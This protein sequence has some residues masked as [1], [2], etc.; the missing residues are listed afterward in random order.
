LAVESDAILD[1]EIAAA[2]IRVAE[3]QRSS[4]SWLALCTRGCSARVNDAGRFAARSA[5]EL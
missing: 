4:T 2:A 3:R 1:L 5:S